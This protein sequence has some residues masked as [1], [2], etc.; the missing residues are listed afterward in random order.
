MAQGCAGMLVPSFRGVLPSHQALAGEAESDDQNLVLW[1]WKDMLPS[2]VR[3]VDDE[4]RL[5]S[6]RSA[7]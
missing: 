1:Q 6:E 4:G 2:R 3:L 7:D 5:A